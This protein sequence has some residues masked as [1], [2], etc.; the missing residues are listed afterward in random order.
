MTEPS[1][2]R[3]ARSRGAL[4]PLFGAHLADLPAHSRARGPVVCPMVPPAA[5]RRD[6][7]HGGMG[8]LAFSPWY[9]CTAHNLVNA[10]KSAPISSGQVTYGTTDEVNRILVIG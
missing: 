2:W 9:A 8:V 5:Q 7:L 4:C 3:G 1:T 6:S 10:A